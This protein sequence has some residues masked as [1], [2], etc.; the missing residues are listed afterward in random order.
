[1]VPSN[2][3]SKILGT[4][5]G[6]V[7]SIWHWTLLN[8][9]HCLVQILQPYPE[10]RNACLPIFLKGDAPMA[11]MM[12]TTCGCVRR[13][14]TSTKR[15][16]R[17]LPGNVPRSQF[18]SMFSQETFFLQPAAKSICSIGMSHQS[19]PSR[20]GMHS[21]HFRM[22]VPVVLTKLRPDSELQL[23]GLCNRRPRPCGVTWGGVCSFIGY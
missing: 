14:I 19:N 5:W 12:S 17:R 15:S 8:Y 18:P 2:V 1:M 7:C 22:W 16:I 9:T 20:S 6:G 23:V 4:W 21:H 13:G 11:E 3:V 10:T